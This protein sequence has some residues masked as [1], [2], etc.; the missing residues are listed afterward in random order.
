M[1]SRF[2]GFG[3]PG[4]TSGYGPSPGSAR[5]GLDD[6]Q[7][8]VIEALSADFAEVE[9]ETDAGNGKVLA[10][11]GAHAEVYRE[12]YHDNRV[13]I[14]CLLPRRLVYHIHG[15]DVQVRVK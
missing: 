13:T 7:S 5:Q 11:L 6:L 10:Y 12:K 15:P 2:G 8:A 9:V 3:S 14:R 1:R 4:G